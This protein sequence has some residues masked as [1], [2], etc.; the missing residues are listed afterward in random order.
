MKWGREKTQSNKNDLCSIPKKVWNQPQNARKSQESFMKMLDNLFHV[1][2]FPLV[3]LC[4]C[5]LA[6]GLLI[7]LLGFYWD[8][9]PAL[10]VSHSLG[11]SAL[12]EFASFDRPF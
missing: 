4:V 9:W 11:A 3:L 8:D 7:P 1:R 6:Y 12:R 2:M 10:W 5:V